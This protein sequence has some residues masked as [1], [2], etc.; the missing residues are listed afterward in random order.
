[1][2]LSLP[3]YTIYL[4]IFSVLIWSSYG[5]FLSFPKNFAVYVKSIEIYK[6]SGE[7]GE[8]QLHTNDAS[9]PVWKEP[10]N[11][12]TSLAYAVFGTVVLLVGVVDYGYDLKY[13]ETPQGNILT[14]NGLF[15]VLFGLSL[16][17]L[18]M[19]WSS[20]CGVVLWCSY[21]CLCLCCCIYMQG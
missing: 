15:S 17:F 1:M 7:Y 14:R 16:I 3:D 21:C 2:L 13:M 10:L 8:F 5:Y 4:V 20:A 19:Y 12:F 6:K 9:P 11:S 18:G